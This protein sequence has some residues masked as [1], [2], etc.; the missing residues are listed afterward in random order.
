MGSKNVFEDRIKLLTANL[1]Y[2][3]DGTAVEAGTLPANSKIIA[4]KCLVNTADDAGTTAIIDIGKSDDDN[5]W[6][7]DID[8]K[9]AAGD[10]S[11]TMLVPAILTADTVIEILLTEAGTAATAGDFDIIIEYVQP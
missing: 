10:I 3:D 8:V 7:N 5:Y 4:I 2:A 11:V 6:A 9:T 1:T